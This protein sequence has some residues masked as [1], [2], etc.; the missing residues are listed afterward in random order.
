MPDFPE[1]KPVKDVLNHQNDDL[2]KNLLSRE[3]FLLGGGIKD[4]FVDRLKE[5]RTNPGTTALEL[6]GA[7]VVGAGLTAMSLAGG[8][9]GTAARI[10][11]GALEV[12]AIGDGIRRLAPTAYAMGDTLVNPDHYLE[13]RATVARY[14]GSAC[15]DY[16]LMA[17][18]G[19]VGSAAAGLGAKAFAPKI[20][21]QFRTKANN[22]NPTKLSDAVDGIYFDRIG[23]STKPFQP[24][25][26]A[27]ENPPG[28]WQQNVPEG[29]NVNWLNSGAENTGIKS[30]ENPGPAG[31]PN[32]PAG[33]DLSKWAFSPKFPPIE[34]SW[35]K[36]Q[37]LVI[38]SAVYRP[39]VIPPVWTSWSDDRQVLQKK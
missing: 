29:S 13:N 12:L 7:A 37:P 39:L 15:F 4:G 1:L 19:M 25:N 17:A 28:A 26:I 31:K 6:T 8:R 24:R 21:D 35:G 38:E 32:I 30:P 27:H 10:G 2:P 33:L 20:S 3:A 34:I 22:A 9:W 16:P 36:I 23:N 14:L 11:T 18:G 5:A